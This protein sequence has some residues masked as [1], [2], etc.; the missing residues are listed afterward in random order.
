MNIYAN[1]EDAGLVDLRAAARELRAVTGIT[2][3]RQRHVYVTEI[4]TAVL[5]DIAASL[6]ALADEARDAMRVAVSRDVV[7]DPEEE[8]RDF[9]VKG[10][11]VMAAGSTEPGEVVGFG[12]SEG[13]I[14][15]DVLFAG[16]SRS[17]CWL[18]TLTRLVGDEAEIAEAV[19]ASLEAVRDE[20]SAE[21]D[22]SDLV[23][24]VDADFEGDPHTEAAAALERL[25]AGEAERRAAK[26]GGRK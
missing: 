7:E 26:K 16:G 21:P 20:P 11:L 5:L 15:A 14:Y 8:A 22:P 17:R 9:L 23:D 18:D 10:D 13:A 1:D 6:R 2:G 24:D 25:K 3:E 4:Q 19:E 12:T